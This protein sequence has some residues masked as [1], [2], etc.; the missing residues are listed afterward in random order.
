MKILV[1]L[2]S[3]TGLVLASTAALGGNFYC[4]QRIIKRGDSRAR[5]VEKCGP[6]TSRSSDLW[7]YDR[8]RTQFT[9]TLHF[10][11]DGTVNRI[12]ESDASY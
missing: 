2:G 11:A 8:G 5:V 4:G 10:R 12:E 6:P 7:V 3:L 9:I 1:I